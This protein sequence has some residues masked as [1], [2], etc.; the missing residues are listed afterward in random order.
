MRDWIHRN[1][2]AVHPAL[3]VRQP[4]D[5]FKEQ[6]IVDDKPFPVKFCILFSRL[7]KTVFLVAC[8]GHSDV[9]PFSMACKPLKM[10]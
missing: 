3:Q 4:I 5:L 6:E 10:K 9:P 2:T 7:L 1:G 8:A